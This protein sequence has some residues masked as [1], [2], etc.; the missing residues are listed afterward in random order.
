[1][2]LSQ[3]HPVLHSFPASWVHVYARSIDFWIQ[4]RISVLQQSCQHRNSPYQSQVCEK[5]GRC[6]RAWESVCVRERGVRVCVYMRN[7]NQ[8]VIPLL[9]LYQLPVLL[10]LPPWPSSPSARPPQHPSSQ[11][12]R[13]MTER[14]VFSLRDPSPHAH[15]HKLQPLAELWG[16]GL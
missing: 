7:P 13:G 12:G 4:D 9:F 16:T 5:S 6:L 3:L 11:S 10:F 15:S 14:G 2:I 8:M 1:M